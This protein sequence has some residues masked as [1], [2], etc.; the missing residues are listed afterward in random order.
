[1]KKVLALMAGLVLCGSATAD[2][3][4]VG[5]FTGAYHE[6]FNSGFVVFTPCIPWRTFGGISDWCTPGA[7]GCHTT[8]GWSF[9]C[10]LNARS[11]PYLFGSADGYVRVEFDFPIG[12]FGG[13]FGNH[14]NVNGTELKFFNADGSVH[15]TVNIDNPADCQ[16]RW[17][18]FETT[19]AGFTAV[20]IRSLSGYNNGAF[21]LMDDMEAD[22]F[23]GGGFSLGVTGN[24]PGTMEACA[25]GATQGDKIAIIYSTQLGSAGPVPGCPGLFV[26]LQNP[27]VASQG[28]ADSTGSYC[29]SGNVPSGACGHVH[30]QA[31]NRTSCEKSNVVDL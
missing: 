10:Q 7:S 25:T 28:T 26:D 1:M 16:W 17:Y 13:Y 24:C 8:G 2:M 21:V 3:N 6:D 29:A 19:D 27:T 12:K 23:T 31:V 20:E 4:P 14:T 22:E 15:A 11:A 5:P 9:Y 18:G 30:V